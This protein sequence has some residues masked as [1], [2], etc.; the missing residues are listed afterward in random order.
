MGFAGLHNQSGG[1][2]FQ[3]P[4]VLGKKILTCKSFEESFAIYDANFEIEDFALKKV[5]PKLQNYEFDVDLNKTSDIREH[6]LVLTFG[7]SNKPIMTFHG[8]MKPYEL[9]AATN[10]DGDGI[11]LSRRADIVSEDTPRKLWF[12]DFLNNNVVSDR[13]MTYYLEDL[14]RMLPSRIAGKIKK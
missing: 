2:T 14:L 13:R 5:N 8:G 3:V 7:K 6:D 4:F 11:V 12:Q 10:Q 9:A 1:N